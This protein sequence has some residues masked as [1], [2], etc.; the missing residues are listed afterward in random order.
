MKN[1][2]QKEQKETLSTEDIMSIALRDYIRG[3]RDQTFVCRD[4]GYKDREPIER[5][6]RSYSE[7][8]D[9]ER[10]MLDR[11]TG[12]ILEIGCNIGEHLRY[13]QGRGL[14]AVGIDISSGAVK[15]AAERGVKNVFLMDARKMTFEDKTFDAVLILYYGFGL[16]GT[17]VNQQKMLQDIFRI[18]TDKCTVIGSSIDALQTIDPRH[19]AYQDYNKE[20]GKAYG[21]ITQVTL[22]MQHKDKFGDWY[23]LL[24]VNPAGLAKLVR[25]TDWKISEIIP[26]KK[27]GRA[28]Y[29]ILRK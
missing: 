24:F 5:Y 23:D 3:V 9:V 28:W 25:D 4:D 14:D 29:Y 12:R 13:L 18:T 26:E 22:R 15:M 21:D 8:T 19:L 6:L 27:G 11:V 16:G 17:L 7:W 20:R 1:E 2:I 10:T